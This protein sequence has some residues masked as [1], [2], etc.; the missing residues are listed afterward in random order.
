MK[1]IISFVLVAIMLINLIPFGI[2]A[3]G[4]DHVQKPVQRKAG[5]DHV[6]SIELNKDS[7][8]F[9]DSIGDVLRV[10]L[11]YSC[12]GDTKAQLVN[13][14]YDAAK[15][16]PH[17]IDGYDMSEDII[18]KENFSQSS[19]AIFVDNIAKYNYYFNDRLRSTSCEIAYYTCIVNNV[20][21][22]NWVVSQNNGSFDFATGTT[23]SSIYFKFNSLIYCLIVFNSLTRTACD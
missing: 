14:R 12:T 5:G 16:I 20:G 1:K 15:L 13:L 18:G 17:D 6:L 8:K 19:A 10:D 7:T 23:L 3:A 22:I 21:Y 9:A 4:G 2:Y 11:K